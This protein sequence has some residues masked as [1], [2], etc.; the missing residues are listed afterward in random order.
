[1]A[2]QALLGAVILREL[3]VDTEKNEYAGKAD[4]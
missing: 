3:R 4:S 1:M 2:G